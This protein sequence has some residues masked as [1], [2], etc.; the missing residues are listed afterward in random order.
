M[1]SQ[2]KKSLNKI[3]FNP[4]T[5]ILL[6]LIAGYFLIK[7][8]Q[9]LN[10]VELSRKNIQLTEKEVASLKDS[11]ESLDEE[12]NKASNPLAKEKIVRDELLQQKENEFVLKLPDIIESEIKTEETKEKSNFE[13][14]LEIVR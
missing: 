10:R 7:N 5:A 1:L 4:I 14:W 12:L 8:H 3:L 9:Q 13:A 2:I 11:V 6:S